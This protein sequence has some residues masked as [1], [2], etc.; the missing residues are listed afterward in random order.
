MTIPEFR[1]RLLSKFATAPI[2]DDIVNES[3]FE[4]HFLTPVVLDVVAQYTG[5]RAYTHPWNNKTRC[6]PDC[7]SAPGS[8]RVVPGCPRCW[9]ASKKWA[10]VLAFGTHHTFDIMARDASGQTLAVEAKLIGPKKGHMPSGEIQRFLGQCS[11][12]KTKH[13]FVIGVCG[14]K[15]NLNPKW[16]DDTAVVKDWLERGGID[17][18]FRSF[19]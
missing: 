16:E 15:G 2:P 5:V 3:G 13:D 8:G 1:D 9:T 7:E 4:K 17:I 11:L 12:A 6:K 19:G 18:V 14:L 10:S